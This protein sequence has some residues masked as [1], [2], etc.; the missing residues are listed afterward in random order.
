MPSGEPECP[1][2]V[3]Y[4]QSLPD[5]FEVEAQQ[6]ASLTGWSISDI[7]DRMAANGQDAAVIR[8]RDPDDP[9]W[10]RLWDDD[11]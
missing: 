9:W 2:A 6:L 8:A 7:R 4:M 11:E 1:A 5:R 10:R 3:E